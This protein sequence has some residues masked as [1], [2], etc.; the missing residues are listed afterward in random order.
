[1]RRA[2]LAFICAFLFSFLSLPAGAVTAS[3]DYSA[4][5]WNAAESGW[6]M[7]VIQQEQ[8]LFITLF[9]YGPNNAPTWLVSSANFVSAN[10][11]GD[12]TYTGDLFATT[13]TPYAVTPFN[14]GAVTAQAVGT[15]TFVGRADG[16]A[17][18]QYNSGSTVVNKTLTRQTFAQPNFTLNTATPYVVAASDTG[19]GCAS[20][21]DNRRSNTTYSNVALYINGTTMRLEI[22]AP[23]GD[24]GLCVF[25]GGNY[26]QEGRY[27]K[28]TLTGTCADFPSSPLTWRVREVEVGAQYFT[29]LYTQTG[30]PSTGCTFNGVMTGA[31]K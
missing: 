7:N 1:M 2:G 15:I 29:L 16:T 21:S 8:I 9:V 10:G 14:T 4:I 6:G 31:K 3:T 20:S 27:G 24:G 28:A 13:G 11:A 25:Q 18:V 26:V 23:P 22:T 30:G 12:R 5:W 19:T 17:T